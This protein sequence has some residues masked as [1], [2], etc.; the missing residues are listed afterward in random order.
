MDVVRRY[1]IGE[2]GETRVQQNERG[3]KQQDIDE[4]DGGEGV[5]QNP[6]NVYVDVRTRET[7]TEDG[8]REE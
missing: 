4:T 8:G 1:W 3:N 2:D 5:T 7:K 6:G